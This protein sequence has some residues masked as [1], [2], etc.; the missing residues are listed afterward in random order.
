MKIFAL[1]LLLPFSL[2]LADDRPAPPG[3]PVD[4]GRVALAIH[5]GS[6]TIARASITLETD[7]RFR[8]SLKAALKAGHEVLANGGASLDAVVAAIKVMEDDP[9]F[10][11]GKGAVFT[12]EA[13]NELDASIMD[14][15]SGLAGAVA[16]VTTIKNPIVAA[17]AVMDKTRHVLLAGAGAEKFATARK[18]EIVD[19]SYFATP[20]R[21][22][23]L[24]R[25]QER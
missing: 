23:Q 10:N 6:G 13:K 7:A 20:Q 2:A 3:A 22:E 17:R 25:A 16:G 9:I 19:P 24:K 18:L 8:S 5:G 15:K 4:P 12:S 14:G 11:A 21:L 1:L